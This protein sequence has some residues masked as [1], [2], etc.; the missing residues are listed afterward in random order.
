MASRALVLLT[1]NRARPLAFEVG[2]SNPVKFASRLILP[3]NTPVEIEVET[4][5]P[6]VLFDYSFSNEVISGRVSIA[7]VFATSGNAPSTSSNFLTNIQRFL[8]A[9]GAGWSTV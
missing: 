7:F 3:P 4:I 2:T 8:A 9:T 5:M 1:N 6:L